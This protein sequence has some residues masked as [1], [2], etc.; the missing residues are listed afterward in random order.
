MSLFIHADDLALLDGKDYGYMTVQVL[1]N[2][3]FM[4]RYLPTQDVDV[5]CTYKFPY[6]IHADGENAGYTELMTNGFDLDELKHIRF[7]LMFECRQ[8]RSY[9]LI[10][11]CV[12]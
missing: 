11:D 9:I 3:Y 7:S 8:L 2:G 6:R 5:E 10:D 4:V 12:F 1:Q